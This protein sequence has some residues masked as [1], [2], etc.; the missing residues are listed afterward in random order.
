MSKELD[1]ANEQGEQFYKMVR[2]NWDF[3]EECSY[4][5]CYEQG[6]EL[7]FRY[8][9]NNACHAGLGYPTGNSGEHMHNLS[10]IVDVIYPR[11]EVDR[12]LRIRYIDYLINC[13]A[14]K[15]VIVKDKS[16]EE[17]HDQG[18][19]IA[20]S[21]VPSNQLASCLMSLRMAWERSHITTTWGLLVEMGVDPDVAFI[22]SH[23]IKITDREIRR[24][25]P[26]VGHVGIYVS[27]MNISAVYNFLDGV[28]ANPNDNYR[29]NHRYM[30]V[31]SMFGS[32]GTD[33]H[34]GVFTH[35]LRD[36]LDGEEH[37]EHEFLFHKPPKENDDG[38][39][40]NWEVSE[41]NMVKLYE[42]GKMI[43]E[44]KL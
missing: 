13:P 21:D 35:A 28:I 7:K 42:L 40:E 33:Y 17:L 14:Y 1:F 25:S 26:S 12:N 3:P 10:H 19:L 8:S 36:V 18:Y 6:G 20:N 16:V 29:D 9:T 31:S 32:G 44:R 5:F 43:E 41:E 4:G 24:I 37:E 23:S 15:D 27:T 2:D 34:Y 11:E 22:M 30:P 38:K 39:R